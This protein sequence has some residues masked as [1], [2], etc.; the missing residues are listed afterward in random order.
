MRVAHFCD[1]EPGRVDGVA[2]SA[3]RTV[4]LL[5]A[6]GH[7]VTHFH[8]GPLLGPRSFGARRSVPLPLRALRVAWPWDRAGD[9]GDVDVVHVHTTGPVGMAGFRLAADRGL[10]LV[11]TW[12][13]DLVAYGS[14]YP[15]VAAG[16]AYDAISLGLGWRAREHLELLDPGRRR[17]R[18]L[19][20]GRG[21][22]GRASVFIAPSAKAAA[23]L[24][25]FGDLPPVH[26]VPTPVARAAGM[27]RRGTPGLTADVPVVLSVGRVTSDKNP[28]LLLHAFARVLTRLPDAHLVLLGVRQGGRRVR[29]LIREL[30]LTGRVRVLPPVPRDEVAGFYRAA[31][32]L[33]FA[34]TTDTQGLVLAEAEAAGLPVVVADPALA[35]RPGD[36]ASLRLTCRAAPDDFAGALV[37]ML[38]DG[39]LRERTRLAGL[40]AAAAYPPER[41]LALLTAAYDDARRT[42][43][44][45]QQAAQQRT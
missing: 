11:I 36:P 6:A 45:T 30:G 27:A 19:R 7:S 35:D 37:R 1:C 12:H 18:L 31:D 9:A 34:S 16:A 25:E 29:A 41:F 4:S 38:T 3:G 23:R 15:E 32:V 14:H 26:I 21:F 43:A 40:R 5:R 13:T 10:P 44:P 17:E 42:R 28:A 24:A 8:P 39:D 2:A 22:A 20:L 33:A